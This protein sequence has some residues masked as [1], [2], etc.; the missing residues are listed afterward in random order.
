VTDTEW[1]K[2]LVRR[3]VDGMVNQGRLDVLDEVASGDVAR[4]AREWIG[5]FRRSFPDFSMEIV[6]LIA[7]GDK[8][9]GHFTCSGTHTGEWMGHA[10]TGRRFQSVD[11]IYI[12]S[13]TN[14]KLSGAVAVEDNL[15]RLQQLGLLAPR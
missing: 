10:P 9:V 8:V 6:E 5:P 7:E 2:A 1:S 4:A 3:L 14:G 15:A 11:E 12:F 13:V